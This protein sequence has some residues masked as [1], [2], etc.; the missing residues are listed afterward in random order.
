MIEDYIYPYD[1]NREERLIPELFPL[2]KENGIFIGLFLAEGNTDRGSGCS[3]GNQ[4]T[5][6]RGL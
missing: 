1:A 2:N 5:Q 3:R 6:T 4:R